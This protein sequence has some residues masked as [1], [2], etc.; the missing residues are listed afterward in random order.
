M[1]I[2]V[3]IVDDS[4]V[5]LEMISYI[6]GGDPDLKVIGTASNGEE[7][8]N[9]IKKQ[10]PDVITMD[11]H[12]PLMDGFEAT[13]RIM[14]TTPI[15]IVIVSASWNPLEVG[16]TFK[17][18]EAGALTLLE[19][20]FG[21]GH[22][23]YEQKARE[24]IRVVKDMAEVKV[25]RRWQKIYQKKTIAIKTAWQKP[26][27]K[28][29]VEIVAIGASTGGPLALKTILSELPADFGAP[30]LVVQHIAPGFL[31]G[32]VEWLQ[33]NTK[34]TIHIPSHLDRLEA[35]HVYVAPDGSHL[36]VNKRGKVILS[37]DERENSLRPSVSYL[38][39]S[40]AESYGGLA[41]G[42]LLTGMG[43]DGARELKLISDLQGVTIAQDKASSVVYGMPGEAV[44][45][46]SAQY[47]LPLKEISVIL[48]KLVEKRGS[49]I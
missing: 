15:P 35:G 9:F 31:T 17:A 46:G 36:G 42:V 27:L 33:D 40:V 41:A 2:K 29:K 26:L 8:I 22:P 32:M 3:L 44:R 30:I 6:L 39:R 43:M 10:K 21:P 37:T 5:V 23:E 18:I 28:S 24:M 49:V 48:K 34:L 14:A 19:K 12:M 13:S 11:I 4:P 25:V 7:A 47:V 38:F 45:N 20:P 16:K 1:M